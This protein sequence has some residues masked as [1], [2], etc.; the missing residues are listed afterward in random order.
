MI[1]LQSGKKISLRFHGFNLHLVSIFICF[2]TK[3]LRSVKLIQWTEYIIL[4]IT[5]VRYPIP[6]IIL[7]EGNAK[8]R[9]LKNWHVKGLCGR[10]L[11]VWCPEPLT[12]YTCTLYTYS[13][14]EGGR[15]EI[16][17]R[18]KGRGA[19]VHKAG[20][21]IPAWL[22]VYPVYNLWWTPAANSIYMSIFLDGDILLW[23]L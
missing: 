14:M 5:E 12:H 17:A 3:L 23:C 8:C 21:K 22:T 11:S 13:H 10:C 7:I 9:H 19:K 20:S 2:A 6:K 1:R 15:G 4:G 18:G 16:W